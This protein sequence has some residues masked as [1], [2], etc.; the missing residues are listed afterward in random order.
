MIGKIGSQRKRLHRSNLDFRR[1]HEAHLTLQIHVLILTKHDVTAIGHVVAAIKQIGSIHPRAVRILLR[2]NRQ[3]VSSTVSNGILHLAGHTGIVINGMVEG[4]V[5]AHLD[6]FVHIKLNL[7]AKI[8]FRKHIRTFLDDTGL[9]V[10]GTGKEITDPLA[11]TAHREAVLLDRMAVVKQ[12]MPPVI[13]SV[14]QPLIFPISGFPDH[15]GALRILRGIIDTEQQLLHVVVIVLQ[16]LART[17]S[18][19]EFI[20]GIDRPIAPGL[21]IGRSGRPFPAHTTAIR[22]NRIPFF[23]LTGFGRNENN[24]PCATGTVNSRS[25]CIFDDRDALHII[26]IDHTHITLNT[27]DEHKRVTTIDGRITTDVQR[28]GRTRLSL[29]RCDIQTGNLALQH[30]GQVVRCAVLQFL[31]LDRRNR[32]GQVHLFLGTVTHHDGLL[33]DHVVLLHRNV[34]RTLASADLD[35][36]CHIAEAREIQ[37]GITGRDTE[38][39]G[40][41]HSGHR[42]I[43]GAIHDHPDTGDRLPRS[44]DDLSGYR[45]GLRSQAKARKQQQRRYGNRF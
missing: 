33:Q 42:A 34:H 8:V 27:I 11:T 10:K 36:L 43:G 12:H 37:D 21:I 7:G 23:V 30:I 9:P 22:H 14:I 2:E 28:S 5:V 40:S 41:I 39:P 25:R 3:S 17:G 20:D 32:T 35:T 16:V 38:G 18:R 29:G 45:T 15:P 31:G 1:I 26:G 13:I 19:P 24:T 44:I 6:V 4:G